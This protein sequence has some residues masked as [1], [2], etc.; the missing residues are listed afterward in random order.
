MN[1]NSH[2]L[3]EKRC[4]MVCTPISVVLQHV[5]F[6]RRQ[7]LFAC[8]C[9][10]TLEGQEGV[11]ESGYFTE[12]LT[13]WFHKRYLKIFAKN[14]DTKAGFSDLQ[15]EHHLILQELE[16]EHKRKGKTTDLHFCMIL[17]QNTRFVMLQRGD[18]NILL[19]NKRYNTSQIKL[20][21]WFDAG[22]ACQG[23]IQKN[24]GLLLCTGGYAQAAMNPV[25]KEALFMDR[26]PEDWRLKK[27][28]FEVWQEMERYQNPQ[29]AGAVY[30]RTS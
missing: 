20:W 15:Q 21:N 28:L 2:Y 27:R 6:E 11:A 14:K 17:I 7:I 23:R 9:E 8:V 10:S 22:G 1:F 29:S 12:R 13:E 19:L 30:I 3:W 26:K 16:K 24:L 25:C 5:E 4:G 18:C